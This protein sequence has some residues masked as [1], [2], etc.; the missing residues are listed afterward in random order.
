MRSFLMSFATFSVIGLA[1]ESMF[2]GVRHQLRRLWRGH[3]P[4]WMLPCHTY[5]W[6]ILVFGLSSAIA[7]PMIDAALPG[8]YGW[9]WVLRGL[10]FAFGTYAWEF[11]WGFAIEEL[12][13]RCPWQ[14]KDSPWRIWRYCEPWY[15]GY[16]FL[17]GFV[18]EWVH[19]RLMPVLQ[20]WL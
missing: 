14:Y 10:V 20:D 2:T 4:D 5:S 11:F 6:S 7:F 8:F 3:R 12:T 18:L 13:G 19:L 9:H 1:T 15:A 17:Y 16:W